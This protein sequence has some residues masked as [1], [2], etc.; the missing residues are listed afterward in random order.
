MGIEPF[1]ISS[2]MLVVC[3]QRLMRRLCKCKKETDPTDEERETI[4]K[5]LGGDGDFKICKPKGCDKCNKAGYKGRTGIH[6]VMVMNDELRGQVIKRVSSEVLKRAAMECGMITLYQD[7]LWKVKEGVSSLEEALSNVR[8][9][10]LG[11]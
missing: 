9:D 5:A 4:V 8:A 7:A 1:L 3:A 6:E 10:D 2:S 11:T